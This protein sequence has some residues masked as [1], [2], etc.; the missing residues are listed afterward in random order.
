[1]VSDGRREGN[2]QVRSIG[3]LLDTLPPIRVDLT[4]KIDIPTHNYLQCK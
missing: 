3:T 1:M 4:G 2:I